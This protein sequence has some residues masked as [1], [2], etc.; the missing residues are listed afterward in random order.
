MVTCKKMA[1]AIVLHQMC[2]LVDLFFCTFHGHHI[3]DS[4]SQASYLLKTFHLFL[5]TLF[6]LRGCISG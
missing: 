6:L 1:A 4:R 3:H 5:A 2:S